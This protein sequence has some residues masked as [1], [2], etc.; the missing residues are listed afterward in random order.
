MTLYYDESYPPWLLGVDGRKDADTGEA[1][2][3]PRVTAQNALN[4]GNLTSYGFR[5]DPQTAWATGQGIFV[6]TSMRFY[7]SGT[8]WVAGLAPVLEEEPE[9]E[10]EPEPV[11][12]PEP[13]QEPGSDL[14]A[15]AQ[16]PPPDGT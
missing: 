16:E 3:D 5:A 8:A 6:N 10:P 2:T 11:P 15:S 1:F 7:W 13:E 12:E 9:P 14:P 4:A